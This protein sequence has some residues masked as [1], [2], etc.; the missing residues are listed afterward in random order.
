MPHHRKLAGRRNPQGPHRHDRQSRPRSR[1]A[2]AGFDKNKS[3]AFWVIGR[4]IARILQDAGL[5]TFPTRSW[6]LGV[7]RQ[8]FLDGTA[9]R[10][11]GLRVVN[12]GRFQ[13][14]STCGVVVALSPASHFHGGTLATLLLFGLLH[15]MAAPLRSRGLLIARVR[16][17]CSGHRAAVCGIEH[18]GSSVRRAHDE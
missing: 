12:A 14:A 13:S 4:M 8:R 2:G 9:M 7:E 11:S 5:Q 3:A 15:L 6:Q 1:F 17:A 18:A 10:T 16:L